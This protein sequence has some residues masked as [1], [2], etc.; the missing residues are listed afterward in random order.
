MNFERDEG[1][2]DQWDLAMTKYEGRMKVIQQMRIKE[3]ER[4]AQKENVEKSKQ[5]KRDGKAKKS[6]E[7]M[8]ENK[9]IPTK[10]K[11]DQAAKG[12][13]SKGP[14]NSKDS[15]GFAIP[16]ARVGSSQITEGVSAPKRVKVE[17]KG[18][19][20]KPADRSKDERTI[21]LSN[22]PYIVEESKIK[23]LFSKVGEITDVRLV[24]DF[25][26]KSKGYGYVEFATFDLAIAALK[27]DRELLDGRPVFV[28]KCEEKNKGSSSKSTFKYN[29]GLEKNKLFVKGLPFEMSQEDV[30]EMFKEF[31]DLKEVRLVTY[32]NG[33]SKGLA[34]VEFK[35]EATAAAAL[36]KTDGMVKGESTISVAI[37]NPPQRKERGPTSDD[38]G[39]LF[40]SNLGRGSKDVGARGRGRTQLALMPRALRRPLPAATK[41]FGNG[42]TQNGGDGGGDAKPM[43][44]SDFRSLLLRK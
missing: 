44:N 36:L 5:P 21:F 29:T 22:L 31:G 16:S 41:E 14:P 9:K 37:S 40:T 19:A 13:D 1:T 17:E 6:P 30:T 11:F 3:T 38:L 7:K 18:F 10:R 25:R 35:D 34:F 27:M 42:T 33:H 20:N 15:D 8:A 4:C 32:R 2:L 12:G 23:D 43:S 24:R 26:G 39:L 28:S